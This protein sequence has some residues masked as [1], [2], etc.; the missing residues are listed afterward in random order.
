MVSH[1]ESDILE[2]EALGSTAVN[3][4]SGCN[5]HNQ[6]NF[7]DDH[8]VVNLTQMIIIFTTVGRNPLEETE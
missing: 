6:S 5:E 8:L 7:S 2:G 4:A 3:K 1:P